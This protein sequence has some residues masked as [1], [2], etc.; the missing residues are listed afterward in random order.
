[1]RVIK[2]VSEMQRAAEDLRRAGKTIGLVPTMGFLHDA[3]L[4]L[5]DEAHRQCDA[6][7][8]SLFVNPTQFGPEEDFARYPRDFERDK[9]LM[10][11]SKVEFL[12]C[13][14][15]GDMYGSEFGTYVEEQEISHVLEGKFRPTHFRGVT[16]VVAKLFNIC[17]PHI[18]LFG[19]K[20]A[21]QL[22]IIRKMVRDLNFDVSIVVVPIVREVDGLAMSSRNIYLT[23]EERSKATILYESLKFAEG[24]IRDGETR[25]SNIQSEM[26][27]MIHERGSATVDYVAFVEPETFH[28][29]DV[30]S[31]P[32]VLVAIAARFGR[33]RLIDNAL[34]SV[35]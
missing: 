9:N 30:I 8:V 33:T 7:A 4:K 35:G 3:H 17:K 1:M 29:G 6:V 31:K 21:Q 18:A 23:K 32:S 27:T 12:F 11:K 16:T 25:V 24:K 22:F 2:T 28:E 13:P 20:D 10:E 26:E 5:I 19:Q 34:I 14:E 15:A